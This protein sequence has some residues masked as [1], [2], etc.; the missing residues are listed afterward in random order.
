VVASVTVGV[1]EEAVCENMRQLKI[2]LE[3]DE[4]VYEEYVEA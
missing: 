4:W 3:T 2:R 1:L